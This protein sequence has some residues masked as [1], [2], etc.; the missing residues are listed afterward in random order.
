VTFG[1]LGSIFVEPRLSRL[2]LGVFD[3][4]TYKQIIEKEDEYGNSN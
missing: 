3:N 2:R 4:I 1:A